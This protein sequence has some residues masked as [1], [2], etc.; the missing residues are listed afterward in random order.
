MMLA[1]WCFSP[2][3]PRSI[4]EWRAILARTH[5]LGN[6]AH[7]AYHAASALAHRAA[8]FL[9]FDRK[10]FNRYAE[11]S[12]VRPEDVLRPDFALSNESPF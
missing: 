12:V 3:S 6:Q 11:V 8:F 10:D 2:T 1:R 9:T 5:V 7:D 4:A